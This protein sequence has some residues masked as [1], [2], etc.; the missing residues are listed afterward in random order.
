VFLQAGRLCQ[1]FELAPESQFRV[2][3]EHGID[4]YGT[5]PGTSGFEL[6]RVERP[7]GEPRRD[8][9]PDAEPGGHGCTGDEK[10]NVDATSGQPADRRISHPAPTS[11]V[12]Q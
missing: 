6:D 2:Y 5:W 7:T 11:Q 10:A 8:S 9:R 3:I 4:R 12:T 1:S